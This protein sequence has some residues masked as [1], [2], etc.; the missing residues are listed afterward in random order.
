MTEPLHS[1]HE[2][3]RALNFGEAFERVLAVTG[4]GGKALAGALLLGCAPFTILL[5]LFQRSF[6]PTML[7]WQQQMTQ[8]QPSFPPAVF[9]FLLLILLVALV[10]MG[11][12]SA[13]SLGVLR[14]QQDGEAIRTSSLLHW[15]FA[16]LRRMVPALFGLYLLWMMVFMV[17]LMS[18]ILIGM[19]GVLG[20]I[21]GGIL[22]VAGFCVAFLGLSLAPACMLL[23]DMPFGEAVGS[24]LR[25]IRRAFFQTLFLLL[26]FVFMFAVLSIAVNLPVYLSLFSKT[27][28]GIGQTG[29]APD[30]LELSAGLA[31]WQQLWQ[32][33][34][35]L[36]VVLLQAPIWIATGVQAMNLRARGN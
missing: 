4:Q 31:L 9:M 18:A 1:D 25:W 35:G 5:F 33:L 10:Q 15:G 17:L 34:A 21:V 8:G 6:Q 32:L 19:A 3:E 7:A 2:F 36:L 14:F 26:S 16:Q 24:S 27:L 30:P 12:V 20:T 22:F 13:I 28:A 23:W 29:L 11:L